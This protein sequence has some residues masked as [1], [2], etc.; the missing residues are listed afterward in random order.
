MI[1]S[2]IS[3]HFHILYHSEG[4]T[5]RSC[6][7]RLRLGDV[8]RLGGGHGRRGRGDVS[9]SEGLETRE[10]PWEKMVTFYERCL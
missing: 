1:C 7:G 6:S 2:M 10:R 4:R 5:A 3:F 9:G 8:A